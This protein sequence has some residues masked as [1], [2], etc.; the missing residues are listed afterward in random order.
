[1]HLNW[2]EQSSMTPPHSGQMQFTMADLTLA[3]DR[4]ELSIYS[5]FNEREIPR[6][7]KGQSARIIYAVL[8]LCG[9]LLA[10]VS[11]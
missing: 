9:L 6:L 4:I 11:G 2:F 3:I 10:T 8:D 1:M 5:S 7:G